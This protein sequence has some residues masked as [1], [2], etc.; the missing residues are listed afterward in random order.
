VVSLVVVVKL[1]R[2]QQDRLVHGWRR[3]DGDIEIA[4]N[5]PADLDFTQS[6]T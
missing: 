3:V 2:A 6:M 1:W 5:V 4:N